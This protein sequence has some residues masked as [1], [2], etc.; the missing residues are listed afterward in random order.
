MAFTAVV[1]LA[2]AET[3]TA[4]MVLAAVA[5]VGTAMTIVGAVTGNKELTKIGGTMALVGGIGGMAAGA[6]GA[7]TDAAATTVLDEAASKAGSDALTASLDQGANAMATGATDA[8]TA[9][10]SA[11]QLSSQLSN[12]AANQS[13]PITD[14]AVANNPSAVMQPGQ[15]V[16]NAMD[17]SAVRTAADAGVSNPMTNGVATPNDQ[18]N[19]SADLRDWGGAQKK[20]SGSFFDYFKDTKPDTALNLAGNVLGG[21]SKG[22]EADRNY[23]LGKDRL[24]LIQQQMNWGNS[25]PKY[26]FKA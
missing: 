26:N 23:Q 14:A 7:A 6:M 3:V 5:E 13:A 21:I 10:A 24:G 4:V 1:A 17:N 9:Q 18:F 8:A 2:S 22:Y 16:A 15:P 19:V 20:S 25:T 11:D 12:Q